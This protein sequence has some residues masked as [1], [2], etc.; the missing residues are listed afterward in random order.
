MFGI[1]TFDGD[2]VALHKVRRAGVARGPWRVVR[3][4]YCV[5]RKK[6]QSG[7]K[8][9]IPSDEYAIRTT[10][11]AIR[12]TH[13]GSHVKFGSQINL[14]CFRVVCQKLGGAFD[15]DLA[16]VNDVSAID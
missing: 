2:D 1:E 11:Y 9:H 14:A 4:A 6:S 8:K 10:Q 12:T 15:Q 16:F 5:F 3:I 7:S 13:H